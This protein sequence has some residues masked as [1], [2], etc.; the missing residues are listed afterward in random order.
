MRRFHLSLSPLPTGIDI[1]VADDVIFTKVA[2]GLHFD[3]GHE[4]LSTSNAVGVV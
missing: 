4:Y 2:S 3:Q 1:F